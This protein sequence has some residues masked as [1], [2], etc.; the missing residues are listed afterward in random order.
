MNANDLRNLIRTVSEELPK[1][2]F[3]DIAKATSA[4]IANKD[5]RPALDSIL[6]YYVG[7]VLR[8]DKNRALRS[9]GEEA[10][11][12]PIRQGRPRRVIAHA[13]WKAKLDARIGVA[14]NQTKRLGDLTLTDVA[15]QLSKLNSLAVALD[16]R[17]TWWQNVH[18]EMKAN[19]AKTLSALPESTLAPL[20]EAAAA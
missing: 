2:D 15:F 9:R 5:L 17:I 8:W 3:H 18:T 13:A 14:N 6:P 16:Q 10:K 7:D 12:A 4:R 20:V 19:K 1:G 11:V